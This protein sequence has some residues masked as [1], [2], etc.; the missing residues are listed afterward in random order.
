MQAQKDIF[1]GSIA[2]DPTIHGPGLNPT[3]TIITPSDAHFLPYENIR[4]IWKTH[5]HKVRP[6]TTG[7]VIIRK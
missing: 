5:R 6:L 4:L 3:E 1:Q 2:S 7:Q